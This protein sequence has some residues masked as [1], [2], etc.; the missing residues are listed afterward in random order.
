MESG[1]SLG[2]NH[3]TSIISEG[4]PS[5]D[6]TKASEWWTKKLEGPRD[7]NQED[8]WEMEKLKKLVDGLK[9]ISV[10]ETLEDDN[11]CY[12]LSFLLHYVEFDL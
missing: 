4:Y 12:S 11:F 3:N 5:S 7:W 2:D 6:Q 9:G 1:E 8:S 10:K